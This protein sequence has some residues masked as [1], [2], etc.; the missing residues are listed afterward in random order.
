MAT[1]Q[2]DAVMKP[3]CPYCGN[4]PVP[5]RLYWYEESLNILLTPFRLKLVYNPVSRFFKDKLFLPFSAALFLPAKLLGIIRLQNDPA[6]C[7]VR[8]AQVLWEEANRRG[9]AMSELLLFGR[10]IDV[11]VA[12]ESENRRIGESA[13]A[14]AL[15][16]RSD[17]R[18]KQKSKIIFSG[19]PRPKGYKNPWLEMM[20]DKFL[21][22]QKFLRAGL[23]VARGGNVTGMS[24]ALKIFNTIDK[25]VIVKPRAGSRGRHTTTFVFTEADLRQAVKVA[26]QLCHWVIV[27]EQL[28]GPVYRA[29]IIGG[30]LAGVLGADPPQV[31][32]DGVHSIAELVAI[33][34]SRPHPRV[35][36]I[37][38]D[39]S[40]DIFLRRQQLSADVILPAGK[41]VSLSEKVGLNSGGSSSEDFD[42][43]HP[44]NKELF[45]R[46]AKVLGD[47]VVGFDFIMPDIVASWKNQ[48]CG[49]IEANSLP[50]INLHHD[51]LLGTP[52]NAAALVWDMMG[53]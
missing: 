46:A 7:K 33:K 32:G 16:D 40:A 37:I 6:K 23:P 48:K 11:Y 25:P 50:F 43:C 31:T 26:K 44:D 13:Y 36:D 38:M 17:N 1:A 45:L 47:P 42:I 28:F 21:L 10:P 20:D 34:N 49:F 2:K 51:P 14:K 4:N 9:I 5:H 53:W 19:L 30:K 22:K 12:E 29:T 35:K 27:E 39:S 41:V 8:R 15:A 52:R 18:I 3:V 24:G